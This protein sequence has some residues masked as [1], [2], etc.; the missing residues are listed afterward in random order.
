[1]DAM[2]IDF[3]LTWSAPIYADRFLYWTNGMMDEQGESWN[4]LA[5]RMFGISPILDV[6]P[7]HQG[8]PQLEDYSNQYGFYQS[9][10]YREAFSA[11]D[12]AGFRTLLDWAATPQF[13]LPPGTL[14]NMPRR[15]GW[16]DMG[17]NSDRDSD[18]DGED[19]E[20]NTRYLGQGYGSPPEDESEDEGD[21]EGDWR[22]DANFDYY[23]AVGG[24]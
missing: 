14:R 12:A 16:P 19:D 24:R 15:Q 10:V 21:S 9:E 23:R 5:E 22:D 8:F 18:D 7:P 13:S 2:V 20:D 6:G 11:E 4:H 17:T 1:M 3:R